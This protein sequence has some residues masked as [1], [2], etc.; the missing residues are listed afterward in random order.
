[1]RAIRETDSFEIVYSYVELTQGFYLD[2]LG[3]FTSLND[4]KDMLSKI[5]NN[6]NACTSIVLTLEGA[7]KVLKD[8]GY[9]YTSIELKR[10]CRFF[11]RN[12]SPVCFTKNTYNAGF[13]FTAIY[14]LDFTILIVFSIRFT[15]LSNYNFNSIFITIFYYTLF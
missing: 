9:A 4:R 3:Y 12:Y 1:M 10:A 2:G 14:Y 7:K 13:K 5:C 8:N 6:L 15:L 11:I